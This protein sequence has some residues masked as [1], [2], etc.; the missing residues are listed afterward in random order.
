[1]G[2]S[3]RRGPPETLCEQMGL[4]VSLSLRVAADGGCQRVNLGRLKGWRAGGLESQM[5]SEVR[6][7]PSYCYLRRGVCNMWGGPAGGLRVLAVTGVVQYVQCVQC[8]TQGNAILEWRLYASGLDGTGMCDA[9]A[10]SWMQWVVLSAN[11]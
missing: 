6:R 7:A 1:M 11:G 2:E 9:Y 8:V 4:Q 10:I 3:A 5:M